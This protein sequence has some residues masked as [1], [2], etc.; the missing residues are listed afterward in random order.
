MVIRVT[1]GYQGFQGYYSYYD[2]Q[3]YSDY[4]GSI[5]SRVISFIKV[6]KVNMLLYQVLIKLNPKFQFTALDANQ[7]DPTVIL[8]LILLR[9][10]NQVES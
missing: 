2:Y 10:V 4:Q 1:I 6:I 3:S 8:P 7:V 5:V 9:D